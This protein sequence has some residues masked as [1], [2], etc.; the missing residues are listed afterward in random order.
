MSARFFTYDDFAP[1]LSWT[2]AVDALQHGHLRPRAQMS[3]LF[4]G[5]PTGTLLSR[6]AFIEGL[7]YGAKSVTIFDG[8]SRLGLP[9]VQGAMLVFDPGNGTLTAIIESKLVTEFKTAADSVL[10]ATLLARPDSRHL[11]IAGAGAVAR[12]LISAYPA[13]FPGLTHISIWARRT[14]QAQSLAAEFADSPVPVRAVTDLA[15]TA[16]QS[17]II[18][19]ATMAREPL[20]KGEWIRP[21]THVDLIGAFKHDMREADDQLIASGRLFVDSRESTVGHIGE[22]MIP[23]ANGTISEGNIRGDLYDLIAGSAAGRTSPDEITIFKNGGG[24]HLDLM[25]ARYIA[26]KSD[27]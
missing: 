11:L 27:E 13:L 9:G 4:V 3:D 5:P 16:T 25:T 24:A 7:G 22:I 6:A 12:S 26:S 21:G 17:D 8:N 15:E 19:S 23:I 1:L 20:I 2:E 14:E 10:G 18:A